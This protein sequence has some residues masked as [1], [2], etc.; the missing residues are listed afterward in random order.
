VADIPDDGRISRRSLLIGAAGAAV[1]LGGGAGAVDYELGHHPGLRRRLFGCGSTLPIPHS[2]YTVTTGSVRS[3]AMGTTEPWLVALPPGYTK[4]EALPL[5]ISLPG[6]GGQPSDLTT[7]IGLPGFATAAKL[8]LAFACPGGAGSTYYHPRADGTDCFSWVTEEFP[9]MVERRFAVG[10]TRQRRG[11]YGTSMGGFGA[12]LVALKRPELVS[13]AVASSPAVFASYHAAITGHPDTFDSVADWQRWG[14]WDQASAIREV[15]VRIDCGDEDPFAPTARSLLHQIP[16][17]VGQI[18]T[19]CHEA[20]FWRGT[21][22]VQL[23]F[24][25]RHLTT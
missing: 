23:Q 11:V 18:G 14:V 12:L 8:R 13:A 10:G 5:V 17:A 15:A 21:A 1:V 24:L 20:S 22:A 25:A 3:A 19:G 6:R 16:G 7:G 4:G 9:G 2:S